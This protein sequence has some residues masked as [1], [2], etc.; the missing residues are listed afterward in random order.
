MS[1]LMADLRAAGAVINR[2]FRIMMSFRFRFLT[3]LLSVFFT[4]T[5]FHFISRLVHVSSFRQHDAYFAFVVIGLIT[6]QV[7]NSTL[8]APPAT[9]RHD[10]VAGTME[11]FVLSPLGGVRGML[12]TMVFPFLYALLTAIS[13]LLLA[14]LVFGV[15]LQWSTL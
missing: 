5:L 14:G 1:Y 13:M 3:H 9:L 11:R 4:L 10:L 7:L 15:H 8:Q 12:A 6:L 2:D